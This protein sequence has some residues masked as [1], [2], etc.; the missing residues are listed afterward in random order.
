MKSS[1]VLSLLS[2]DQDF[3]IL[4]ASDARQ[5]AARNGLEVEILYANNNSMLQ[6]EQIY[7]IIYGPEDARPAAIVVQS[8]GGEGLPRVARDA[9]KEGIGWILLNRDVA[10]IDALAAEYPKLPIAIVT[11]DQRGVGHIQ[12]RQFRALLPNGGSVLYI[13][14]PS[15][16]SAARQRLEGMEETIAGANIKVKVLTGEWTEASGE[17]A[18]LWWLGRPSSEDFAVDLIAAQNDAMAVG[19]RKAATARR[20]AWMRLPFTGCDGLPD[21]GQRMVNRGELAATVIVQ[22][23]AGAAI[24]LVAAR[25][26]G[27]AA[28]SPRVVLPPSAYPAMQR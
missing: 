1:I 23:T 20:P 8:V 25:V 2:S 18:V 7:K 4:Q 27:T 21:G 10:Y 24:D 15:D 28:A 17:E 6:V 3:Q 19:A 5:A 16:T 11:A 13:Q 22:P 14:G 26:R 9:V 12:G